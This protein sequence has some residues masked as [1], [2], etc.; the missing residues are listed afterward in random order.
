MKRIISFLLILAIG[1]FSINSFAFQNEPDGFRGIKWGTKIETLRNMIKYAV[2]GDVVIYAR[3]NDKLQIG[4]AELEGIYY[5]FWQD[6]F[7]SVSI[8]AKEDLNCIALK[9]EAVAK[10]GNG[11][12]HSEYVENYTWGNI[13]TG[14]TFMLFKYNRLSNEARFMMYSVKIWLMQDKDNKKKAKEGAESD[15]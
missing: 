3:H 6:K 4:S 2:Q 14:K 11:K 1:T 15:S 9:E 13:S 7:C 8:K 5:F 12:Q 10:F